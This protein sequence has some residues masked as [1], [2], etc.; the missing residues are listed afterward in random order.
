MYSNI[1]KYNLCRI[2]NEIYIYIKKKNFI[3]KINIR[4]IAF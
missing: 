2:A 1:Q 3:L 4:A